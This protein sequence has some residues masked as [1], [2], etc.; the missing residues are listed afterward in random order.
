MAVIDPMRETC[1]LFVETHG[2][3][4]LCEERGGFAMPRSTCQGLEL[5]AGSGSVCRRGMDKGGTG[6]GGV[7]TKDG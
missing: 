4:A 3:A 2:V 7:A 5:G 6:S 1:R